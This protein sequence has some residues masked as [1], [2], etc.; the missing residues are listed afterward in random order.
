MR[1]H[2]RASVRSP[3]GRR[4]A[5]QSTTRGRFERKPLIHDKKPGNRNGAAQQDDKVS[6][7]VRSCRFERSMEA[8]QQLASSSQLR[9][10]LLDRICIDVIQSH[11][12]LELSF[13]LRQGP[14]C[15]SDVI[16]V[17]ETRPVRVS[18]SDIRGN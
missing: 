9:C 7:R 2:I 6:G 15:D 8:V 13:E 1:K 5:S 16:A 3:D 17:S 14:E 11:G 18:F 4:W 10:R 12:D